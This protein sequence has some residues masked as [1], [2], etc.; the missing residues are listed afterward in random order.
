[1]NGKV[2]W[3]KASFECYDRD[4]VCS[5]ECSNYATCMRVVKDSKDGQPPMKK[6]VEEL[7][8]LGYAIPLAVTNGALSDITEMNAKVMKL[9][10]LQGLNDKE[11]AATLGITEKASHEHRS[12]CYKAYKYYLPYTRGVRYDSDVFPNWAKE[13]IMDELERLERIGVVC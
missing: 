10:V 9:W 4:C 13:H 1:M 12:M 7:L 6:C 2:C 11:I 3:T 8:T 5:P